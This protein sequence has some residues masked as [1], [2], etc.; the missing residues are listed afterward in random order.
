MQQ[1][2]VQRQ[3]LQQH[4]MMTAQMFS[5]MSTCLGQLFQHTGLQLPSLLTQQLRT[6]LRDQPA[7][8]NFRRV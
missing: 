6:K 2:E 7:K 4:Q 1:Q 8:K 3:Q 5:F